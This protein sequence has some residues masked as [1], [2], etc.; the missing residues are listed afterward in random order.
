MHLNSLAQLSIIDH[1]TRSESTEIIMG[2][3]M[4]TETLVSASFPLSTHNNRDS[5]TELETEAIKEQTVIDYEL[6]D[7]MLGLMSSSDQVC[8]WYYCGPTLPADYLAI[9]SKFKEYCLNPILVH[10]NTS[11]LNDCQELPLKAY[12][13]YGCLA[14]DIELT[15]EKV[16]S[17][18]PTVTSPTRSS[19]KQH[20]LQARDVIDLLLKKV[21]EITNGSMQYPVLSNDE[22]KLIDSLCFI[23]GLSD[24]KGLLAKDDD[25]RELL[26]KLKQLTE[27]QVQLQKEIHAI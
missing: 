17:L 27:A 1:F 12:V 2:V 14:L 4:G 10:L 5:T 8:G 11:L 6:M 3:L 19:L 18:A 16:V 21:T 25:T 9:C 20:L 13:R 26:L 7:E 24:F 22:F 23:D 15:T